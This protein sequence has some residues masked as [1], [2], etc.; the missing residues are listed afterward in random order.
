MNSKL[1]KKPR[2]KP[3]FEYLLTELAKSN[4][5]SIFATDLNNHLSTLYNTRCV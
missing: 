4:V 3:I 2:D 1:N 5:K